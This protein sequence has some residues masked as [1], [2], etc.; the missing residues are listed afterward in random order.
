VA[1]GQRLADLAH[2]GRESVHVMLQQI[3]DGGI[4]LRAEQVH[5]LGARE[6]AVIA[7][8]EGIEAIPLLEHLVALALERLEHAAQIVELVRP[9]QMEV[10]GGWAQSGEGWAASQTRRIQAQTS[11][12]PWASIGGAKGYSQVRPREARTRSHALVF[13]GIEREMP[14]INGKKAVRAVWHVSRRT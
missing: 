6:R 10:A 11:S 7:E 5:E 12:S 3:I 4:E 9:E 2:V 1:F 14:V 13:R 8:M